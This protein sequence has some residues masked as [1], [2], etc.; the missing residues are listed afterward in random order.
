[1][2][3]LLYSD[4]ISSRSRNSFAY[5][6]VVNP[7]HRMFAR[8]VE[9]IDDQQKD[10]EIEEGEH[11]ARPRAQQD[12]VGGECDE[13]RC[14]RAARCRARES[15]L[16]ASQ[17]RT[18]SHDGRSCV[19]DAAIGGK[20]YSVLSSAA[21]SESVFAG[22]HSSRSHWT[23]S[24][25]WTCVPAGEFELD[26]FAAARFVGLFAGEIELRRFAG[27]AA[28]VVRFIGQCFCTNS[29]LPISA[30]KTSPSQPNLASCCGGARSARRR[31]PR[32][33]PCPMFAMRATSARRASR[34]SHRSESRCASAPDC[35]TATRPTVMHRS[36]DCLRAD[37][38]S[39]ESSLDCRAA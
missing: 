39:C 6:A 36:N 23:F 13:Q 22:F 20:N 12:A 21:N 28:A 35:V 8:C 9:R 27:D 16:A 32:A 4:R 34:C 30:A 17:I 15:P 26:V 31:R 5:H 7:P 14:S 2:I 10:R 29:Q 33:S 38:A 19:C 24:V 11:D 37:R 3:R 25:G 18:R 1:M